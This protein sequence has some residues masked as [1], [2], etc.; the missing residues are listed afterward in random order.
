MIMLTETVSLTLM[1]SAS[2]SA[3]KAFLPD[4]VLQGKNDLFCQ[5][6]VLRDHNECKHLSVGWDP[7]TLYTTIEHTYWL[8]PLDC[9]SS[10]GLLYPVVQ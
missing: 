10:P 6:R 9:Q 3:S 5:S 4:H 2:T 7:V 1:T 8:Y